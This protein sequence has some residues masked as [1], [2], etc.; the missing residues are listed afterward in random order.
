MNRILRLVLSG[1]LLLASF[2]A[3]RPAAAVKARLTCCGT[4]CPAPMSGPVRSCCRA[5]PPQ[6]E[7]A[8][9]PLS[10]PQHF[11]VIALVAVS[12]VPPLKAS[13][14]SARLPERPPGTITVV[15][16]GLSPPSVPA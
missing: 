3:G 15:H 13:I 1:G 8:A 4:T 11:H 2:A 10:V 6:D 9:A 16:S 5:T 12:E 7:I 14:A